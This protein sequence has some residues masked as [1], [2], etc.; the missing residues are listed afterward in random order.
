MPW[1]SGPGLQEL[2]EEDHPR[3]GETGQEG[4]P[5]PRRPLKCLRE[6]LLED[7]ERHRPSR[8]SETV[9]E[10]RAEPP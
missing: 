2:L 9:W 5:R 3:E 4:N 1:P 10:H 7:H 6:E 8:E